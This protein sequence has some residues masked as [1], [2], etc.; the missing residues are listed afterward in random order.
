MERKKMTESLQN[1]KG[2]ETKEELIIRKLEGD[3]P[4]ETE[5]FKKLTVM[6]PP[7]L[8]KKLKTTAAQNGVNIKDIIIEFIQKM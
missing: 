4:A 7:N 1:K 6:L 8:H 5:N 3:T 2:A